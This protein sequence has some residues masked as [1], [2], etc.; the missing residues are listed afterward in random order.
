MATLSK[1]ITGCIGVIKIKLQHLLALCPTDQDVLD[2]YNNGAI[3][4]GNEKVRMQESDAKRGSPH[5]LSASKMFHLG[6]TAKPVSLVSEESVL[7]GGHLRV[8]LES[9]NPSRTHKWHR[10]YCVVAHGQLMYWTNK[11]DVYTT[12]CTGSISHISQCVAISPDTSHFKLLL[13]KGCSPKE[14]TSAFAVHHSANTVTTKK[15]F[16]TLV[17]A[18]SERKRNAWVLKLSTVCQHSADH[19]ESG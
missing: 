1:R 17:V 18:N 3:F 13:Q 7:I 9:S 8:L 2:V 19:E 10:Y 4:A 11:G 5:T 16:V 12:P 15:T 6:A 14:V